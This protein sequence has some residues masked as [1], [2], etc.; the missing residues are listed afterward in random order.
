MRKTV[1][2]T[3]F[4]MMV[5]LGIITP[6]GVPTFK[7]AKKMKSGTFMDLNIDFLISTDKGIVI[8]MAHNFVQNGDVMADPDM[9][10]RIVRNA[11][12]VEALSYRQDAMCINNHVY[13]DETETQFD[14]QLK[15]E[16]NSFL[17]TWLK[18]LINQGFSAYR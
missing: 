4:D 5:K 11:H 14:V 12:M 13:T 3:N 17:N 1:Y 2:E 15:K 16:L 18:N 8:S 9:E 6:E 7:E 10:I